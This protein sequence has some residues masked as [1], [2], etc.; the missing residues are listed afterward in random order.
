MKGNG[1]RVAIYAR[2]STSE[3]EK[4]QTVQIQL[5]RLA[6]AIEERN[7]QLVGKYIDDGY[8]GE[9]LVRPALDLLLDEIEKNTLKLY[10]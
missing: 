1:K 3:Q 4:R 7:W 6:K 9:L 5:E 8:S 10:L 2:V